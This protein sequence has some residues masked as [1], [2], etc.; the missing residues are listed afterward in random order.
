MAL[1]LRNMN[2]GMLW[3]VSGTAEY[4][5]CSVIEWRE[6][7]LSRVLDKYILYLFWYLVAVELDARL[8]HAEIEDSGPHVVLD[9]PVVQQF[10]DVVLKV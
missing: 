7:I 2:S 5:S 1:H 8:A 3:I 9:H 10:A 4:T 6:T